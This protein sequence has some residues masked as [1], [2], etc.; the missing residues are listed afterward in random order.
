MRA[1]WLLILAAVAI[2][3]GTS[4]SRDPNVAKR[5]YLESGNRYFEKGKFREASIMYRSALKKDPRYGDAYYKLGLTALR[6]NDPVSAERALRRAFE[7]LKPG[8]ERNDSAS[9]LTDIYLAVYL[10]DTRRGKT[11]ETE[12]DDF[13]KRLPQGSFDRLRIEGLRAAKNGDLDGALKSLEAANKLQP[14]DP[15]VVVPYAEALILK[16][17]F[18]EAEKLAR[19]L[20]AKQKDF[21]PIYDLLYAQYLRRNRLEDAE[22]IRKLKADNNPASQE[23]RLQLAAHY[24]LL[25]R[26]ADADR[27]VQKM[28]EENKTFS[29]GR[30][31]AGD[32][33]MLFR[34]FDKALSYYRTGLNGSKEERLAAQRKIADA[35]IAQGRRDEA[36]AVVEKEIL[37][38]HPKDPVATALRASLWIEQG[39]RSQLQQALSE[40]ESSLAKMPRN[41]VVRFN[42]GRAYWAKG[43][44]DQ[45]RTQ[46]QAAIDIQPDYLAPRLA[47]T[48]IHLNR[49]EYATALQMAE[50]VLRINVMSIP[51]RLLRAQAL[52][53]MGRHAEAREELNRVLKINPDSIETKFRLG[54]LDLGLKNYAAAEQTFRAC[55]SGARR[56]VLCVIGLAEVYSAQKQFDKAAEVLREED[57]R[58]P[59]RR[60]ILLA[61]ANTSVLAGKY[62]EAIQLF[63]NLIAKDPE[64][65]DLH[66]RLAE[67]YR[68]SGNIPAAIEHFRMV[69]Q[70]QP[71]NPEAGVWLALLLHQTGR[72]AEAKTHYEQI[73]R[74]QP[75]N[76][77]A[78]NNLAYVLAEHGG[79]LD[80]ALTYAQ[81]A[82]QRMPEQPE[83]ADTLGWIYIKK[84]LTAEALDI[85]QELTAK[86]PQSPTFRYHM[87]MAYYQKG[88]K[89][90][91]KRE[92][93]AALRNR[94]K[95]E[96]EQ[97]IRAL[98]QKIG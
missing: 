34:D 15:R 77:I 13:M 47:L 11:Y 62:D 95:S 73:L 66:L 25:D 72:E 18:P 1:R 6:I 20:I 32:F 38:E 46:F 5:R 87:G 54:M 14:L 35:L 85:Y 91:A 19:D 29:Q 70:L 8:P 37:K 52:Q 27:V 59:G 2:A 10:A 89:P 84:R 41:P 45:A 53:G 81:R 69:K 55:L 88:D 4:C 50:T 79:D 74:L 98:L 42:L 48:Q 30:E 90:Q 71:N 75:D 86:Y 31:K 97:K 51:G 63:R 28:A 94:P 56:E 44:I 12:L 78:L 39:D 26:R 22:Q 80:V 67:T 33:Y 40:L 16:D 65:A 24:M 76:A 3:A 49:G 58:T 17:R 64:S 68:R 7:L 43:E 57:K 36:L 93:E 83:I 9:K 60:E 96:E 21:G 92:L 82:R 61:L 23:Y